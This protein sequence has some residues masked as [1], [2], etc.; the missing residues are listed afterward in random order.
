MKFSA[1]RLTVIAAVLCA[2]NLSSAQPFEPNWES[3]DNRPNPEWFRDA[4]FGIFIH[5]GVYSVPSY[6]RKGSYSEWYWNALHNP[7]SETSKFHERVYGDDFTY[8]D[9]ASMFKA[10]LF[11]PDEWADIFS[12][13]GARYVVLTSK[14]HDGFCLWPSPQSWNWNSVDCGPH[15]DLC[16]DLINA[17]RAR[18]IKMGFYYSLYEWYNPLY[19]SDVDRYVDEHMLPQIK[20]LVTRYEPSIVWGDGEWDQSPSTW[21]SEEFLAWLFNN[22]PNSN[23]IVIND[24]WGHGT[25]FNHGGFYTTE[26]QPERA[27]ELLR[28]GRDWEECRGIGASFGYNRNENID[29]YRSVKELLQILINVVCHGGNLLLDIGP[30]ADGRIPVIMQQR[31]LGMGEWLKVNGEAIYETRPW[32]FAEDG[33]KVFYTSKGDAVYAISLEWPGETLTLKHAGARK[34]TDIYL[35][36]YSQPLQWKQSSKGLEISMPEKADPNL[37]ASDAYVFKF[38]SQPVVSNI[39]ISPAGGVLTDAQPKFEVTIQ[40]DTDG[41]QIR[42]TL[43]GTEPGPKSKRYSKPFIVK[44]DAVVRAKAFKKDWIPSHEASV[45]FQSPVEPVSVSSSN[46]KPGLNYVYFEDDSLKWTK[47]ADFKNATPQETGVVDRFSIESRK[48]NEHFGFRFDGYL[49]IPRDGLYTL[50]IESD[51]G[52]MLFLNDDVIIDN[53]GEHGPQEREIQIPM[54]AGVYRI[55]AAFH[56]GMGGSLLRVSYAGPGIEKQLIPADVLFHE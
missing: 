28:H 56:Q 46:L 48:R 27:A 51:D 41:A 17:V 19:L 4:K 53:D 35:L 45:T 38:V 24:R 10:E 30:T 34:G 12:R 31:L 13:A 23:E 18:S 44:D 20:D 29:N 39:E 43:D 2:V 50:Y 33:E 9:F 40:T 52:S 8:Q 36:G 5:W 7:E 26:Y 11:D 1:F 54:R 25:R 15:R 55:A 37:I 3:L 49:Q 21:R 32:R 6:G 47:T 42:Y 22:A 14:H 16:G